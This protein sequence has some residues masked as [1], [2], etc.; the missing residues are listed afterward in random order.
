[1]HDA[2]MTAE[3]LKNRTEKKILYAKYMTLQILMIIFPDIKYKSCRN[4][5]KGDRKWL[6][7]SLIVKLAQ[8]P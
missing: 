7:E 1:M 8:L 4:E 5:Y 3:L 2:F 6:I